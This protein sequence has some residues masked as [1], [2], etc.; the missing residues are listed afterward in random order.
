MDRP[1]GVESAGV[2]GAS[3]FIE[4]QRFFRWRSEAALGVMTEVQPACQPADPP[5]WFEAACLKALLTSGN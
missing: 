5:L 3:G 1:S 2:W 4:A